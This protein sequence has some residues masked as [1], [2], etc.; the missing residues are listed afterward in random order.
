MEYRRERELDTGREIESI[1]F[2]DNLSLLFE[3]RVLWIVFV[4]P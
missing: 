4:S 3:S 1:V 2:Q